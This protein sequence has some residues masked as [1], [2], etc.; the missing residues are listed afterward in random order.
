MG[1]KICTEQKEILEAQRKFYKELYTQDRQV[2]FNITNEMG[3]R[4]TESQ[5]LELEQPINKIEMLK[6]AKDMKLRKA[7]GLDGLPIEF[8]LVFWDE[9]VDIL[10]EVY[11]VSKSIGHLNYTARQ[12][13]ISQLPKGKKD[14][15]QLKNWRPLTLLNVDYKILANI[16]ALR[17]KEVLPN[18]IGPQQTGFMEERQITENIRR[19]MDVIAYVNK[20]KMGC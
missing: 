17:M 19:T 20:R 7:P 3:I 2:V 18:L 16:M 11:N 12:G 8:Y 1:G 10:F 6:A 9:V 15:T 13:V 5:K 14:P 4:L